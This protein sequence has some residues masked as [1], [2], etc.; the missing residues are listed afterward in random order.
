LLI[1]W[2][3]SIRNPLINYLNATLINHQTCIGSLLFPALRSF[4][5]KLS[6]IL[7]PCKNVLDRYDYDAIII[8]TIMLCYIQQPY[9]TSF[10]LVKLRAFYV[11]NV[12]CNSFVSPNTLRLC[13]GSFLLFAPY[14]V[15]QACFGIRQ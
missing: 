10:I 2:G 5:Q 1:S 13:Y 7:Y 15:V 14:V 9:Y 8:L 6:S 4:V 12:C 3:L 11:G